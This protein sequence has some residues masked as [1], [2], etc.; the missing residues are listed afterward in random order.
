MQE[1]GVRVPAVHAMIERLD[2]CARTLTA[3]GVPCAGYQ[4]WVDDA[5]RV[6]YWWDTKAPLTP[7]EAVRVAV[8]LEMFLGGE[9]G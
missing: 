7:L 8:I 5:D 6:H 9:G 3:A 1:P 4:M 2:A